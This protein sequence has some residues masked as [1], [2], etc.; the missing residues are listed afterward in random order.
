VQHLVH[1]RFLYVLGIVNVKRI[2]YYYS[3]TDYIT[4]VKKSSSLNF[5]QTRNENTRW[6]YVIFGKRKAYVVGSEVLFVRELTSF[7]VISLR[8]YN[9]KTDRDRESDECMI[10]RVGF[11]VF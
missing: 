3:D 2:L 10:R 8:V 1:F 11:S 6:T 9:E 4:F 7:T 5:Y